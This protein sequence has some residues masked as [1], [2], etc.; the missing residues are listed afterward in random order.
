MGVKQDIVNEIFKPR[1]NKFQRRRVTI[2]GLNDLIEID[3]M[4][5]AKNK[6]TNRGKIYFSLNERF[7][8]IFRNNIYLN[9]CK[10]I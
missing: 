9:G 7:L 5:M 8:I 6:T 10:R 2:K 1:R 4:D 3:L